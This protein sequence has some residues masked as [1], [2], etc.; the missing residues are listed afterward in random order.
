[1]I[2]AI[3]VSLVVAGL[4]HDS[5]L[6]AGFFLG[7]GGSALVTLLGTI[8]LT[9]YHFKLACQVAVRRNELIRVSISYLY[10]VGTPGQYLLIRGKR[11]PDQF[12]PVGGVYKIFPSGLTRLKKSFEVVDDGL[13]PI[14]ESSNN[15]LRIRVPSR[16]IIGFLKWFESSEDRECTPIREFHEELIS[17]GLL[18][19]KDFPFPVVQFVRRHYEPLRFSNYAKCR[20]L[21]IADIYELSMN[22]EQV[23]LIKKAVDAHPGKLK[24]ATVEQIER[25]GAEPGKPFSDQIALN[26]QWIL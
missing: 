7:V 1:M 20:E 6:I 24:W 13:I 11:F 26:A 3:V 23:N 5:P 22:E 16:K 15:D 21:L 19:A 4:F 10:R 12:Q 14:D 9:K 8:P 2:I 25:H 18:D 17:D